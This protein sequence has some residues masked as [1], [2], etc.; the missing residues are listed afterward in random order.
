[1]RGQA[2][3]L[4]AS[5]FWEYNEYVR[6][7]AERLGLTLKAAG[8]GGGRKAQRQG[9]QPG[10]EPRGGRQGGSSGGEPAGD[11]DGG[12][13]AVWDGQRFVLNMTG[14]WSDALHA[15]VRYGPAA[16]RYSSLVAAAARRFRR[17]Y[18][19]QAGG[20]AFES[21]ELLL[22]ALGLYNE[23]Q[24]QC[25][26]Y[27]QEWLVRLWG[28]AAFA[29]EVAGAVNRCNYNQGNSQ[30]N[31]L[32]GLVSYGP[33]A[34]GSVWSIQGGNRQL[35]SALL[36]ES[37]ADIIKSARVT[38]VRRTE[39][40]RQFTLDVCAEPTAGG[41][42]GPGGAVGGSETEVGAQAA[43]AEA[44]VEAAE[45]VEAVEAGGP[46]ALMPGV[47]SVEVAAA[48]YGPY[49]AVVIAAPLLGSG[50]TIDL[51][52]GVASS[53]AAGGGGGGIG[54]GAAGG[55]GA[56]GGKGGDQGQVP[57][58]T[59]CA[60]A[61]VGAAASDGAA[62]CLSSADGLNAAAT[63]TA[64]AAA[65]AAAAAAAELQRPYQV[66]VTTY[67]AGGRLRPAYFNVRRLPSAS[68]VLVS[69]PGLHC[70]G[71]MRRQHNFATKFRKVFSR[72]PLSPA[73]LAEMFDPDPQSPRVLVSRK[74]YAY[75]RFSPPE[76]FSP[77][78]LAAGLVYGN[79]LEPAASAME[80]AAVAAANSALLVARHLA[81]VAAAEQ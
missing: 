29:E 34:Y 3:E 26:D 40:G 73:L 1:M 45:G 81:A 13:L 39:G 20:A 7:A 23:T 9:G 21:P 74:W 43:E 70:N 4:G 24:L 42:G 58:A 37:G 68:A 25:A 36:A 65:A 28:G 63:A 10:E 56:G 38:A 41:A 71:L 49:D 79:A 78:L 53:S 2:L 47:E 77:F 22:Q 11:E 35:V 12:G 62:A 32:A 31:A 67:V 60:Q 44:A 80:M 33:A 59:L 14:S 50:I 8:A 5:I 17:V 6:A 19:L 66:T 72:E 52:T 30:L 55:N 48:E 57:A 16:L 75:P 54:S 46:R 69:A 27:M 18:G 64:T 61:A 15:A 51:G 76:R